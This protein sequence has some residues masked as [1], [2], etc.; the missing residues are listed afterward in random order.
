[1][2]D[3]VYNCNIINDSSDLSKQEKEGLELE[4]LIN[5]CNTIINMIYIHKHIIDR[6]YIANTLIYSDYYCSISDA[7]VISS[8]VLICR[9][10]DTV[11]DQRF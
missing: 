6:D 1:M 5:D 2:S 9:M 7:L 10:F 4:L 11:R 3:I 8:I